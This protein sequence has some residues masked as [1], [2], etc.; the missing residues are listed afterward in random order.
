MAS[1][2]WRTNFRTFL[3]R[4]NVSTNFDFYRTSRT[5]SICLRSAAAMASD[6]RAVD[7][8][9]ASVLRGEPG[10]LTPTACRHF[11][12]LARPLPRRAR[13]RARA[14][15]PR[16][17]GSTAC[18]SR[19]RWPAAAP[20]CCAPA[21]CRRT[22]VRPATPRRPPVARGRRLR[23]PR[24]R[25]RRLGG[26]GADGRRLPRQRRPA[27]RPGGAGP[28]AGPVPA[29]PARGCAARG[30]GS[31][32]PRPPNPRRPLASPPPSVV[33]TLPPPAARPQSG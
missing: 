6:W 12:Q 2:V 8:L 7:A 22:S 32:P 20:R 10:A 31:A 16:R 15:P 25:A 14:E 17:F 29:E 30:R 1:R 3:S 23:R 33:L 11:L 9:E 18:A 21:P 28:A 26:G 19:W 4:T 24:P 13:A 27:R 5:V